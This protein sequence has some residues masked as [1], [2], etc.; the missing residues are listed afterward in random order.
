MGTYHEGIG[1]GHPTTFAHVLHG[2]F[3]V[4]DIH[5]DLLGSRSL[6]AEHTT[7]VGRDLGILGLGNVGLGRNSISGFLIGGCR[8][9]SL[10]AT[11]TVEEI[12]HALQVFFRV[13]IEAV[14]TAFHGMKLRGDACGFYF[15]C[16]LLSLTERHDIVLRTV[17]DDDGRVIPVQEADGTQGAVLVGLLVFLHATQQGTLRRIVPHIHGLSAVHVE[18]VDRTAPIHGSK[19]AAALTCIF[20]HA[21]F[22][23]NLFLAHLA[24]LHARGSSHERSEVASAGETAGGDVAGVEVVLISMST[25]PA[26]DSLDVMAL[27]RPLGILDAA[28]VGTHHGI[29]SL[30]Q[31]SDDGTQVGSPLA[32]VAHP[33]TAVDMNHHGVFLGLGLGQ[34]DVQGV[35]GLAVIG[36]V[37][38]AVL[39]GTTHVLRLNLLAA[40]AKLCIS[41]QPKQHADG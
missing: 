34:I 39:L 33:G 36:I 41:V 1:G 27:G 19:D 21:A 9:S 26:D 17:E 5:H 28:V 30:E 8:S 32:A 10:H 14:T 23:V 37:E 38:V 16:K 22:H 13:H 4:A 18:Q 20:P 25:Y 12:H 7:A 2:V 29:A 35:E 3:L 40:E 6:H 11:G 15:L 31:G 24:S